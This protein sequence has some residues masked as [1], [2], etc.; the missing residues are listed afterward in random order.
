MRFFAGQLLYDEIYYDQ[1]ARLESIIRAGNEQTWGQIEKGFYLAIAKITMTAMDIVCA[2]TRFDISEREVD[3]KSD[4]LLSNM[5]QPSKIQELQ[6]VH[7]KFNEVTL[8]AFRTNIEDNALGKLFQDKNLLLDKINVDLNC[9]FFKEYLLNR[10]YWDRKSRQ[11]NFGL[12]SR[13]ETG[14]IK[15]GKQIVGPIIQPVH[16]AVFEEDNETVK[17]M[18]QELIHHLCMKGRICNRR[19]VKI[20]EDDYLNLLLEEKI[21]NLYTLDGGAVILDLRDE[22]NLKR[23]MLFLRSIYSPVN[24]YCE[25][26][27]VVA[28]FKPEDKSA[29]DDLR[30]YCPDWAFIEI[31]NAELNSREAKCRFRA[32][33]KRDNLSKHAVDLE[34]LIVKNK[35]YTR[36]QISQMYRNWYR[37]TYIMNEFFPQ[38]KESIGRYFGKEVSVCARDELEQLIGLSGVKKVIGEIIDFYKLQK[39]RSNAVRTLQK[40]TMHMVFYG[41]PGTAKTTVARLVGKILKE[42]NIL[43]TGDMYEVGRSDLVGKYVGWTAKTVKEYFEKAKG[44]VLFNDEAYSLV[45]EQKSFGDEAINTIVQEMENHRDDV[46]VILAGYRQEMQL[47]L[48]KNRGLESRI[49]FY[50]DFPDYSMEELYQILCEMAVKEGL[51]IEKDVKEEFLDKVAKI[52]TQS[53]NGR[54]V[55]NLLDHAKLKQASRVM[56]LTEREQMEEWMILKAVDFA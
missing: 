9:K 20:D 48:N 30:K 50:V 14:R 10:E 33:M 11:Y 38:Y 52:D 18:V 43:E 6:V 15:T 21:Q 37:N 46:V 13:E 16:Y 32:L 44:S 29:S 1:R 51:K 54:I 2:A 56:K 26:Y 42:E 4:L 40:P 49:A 17:S 3:E 5:L 47:L 7:T 22:S 12:V 25:T 41:N 24:K 27:T 23:R 45:D 28:V 34:K 31:K 36:Y 8:N 55:R 35:S 39:I 53:G 19:I